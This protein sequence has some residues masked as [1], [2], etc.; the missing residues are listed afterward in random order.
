MELLTEAP[1]LSRV[2]S[3]ASSLMISHVQSHSY[4]CGEDE[5]PVGIAVVAAAPAGR[6]EPLQ[7]SGSGHQADLGV[8]GLL[9][10]SGSGFAL[11]AA[12]HRRGCTQ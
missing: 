8:V 12:D 2:S 7:L 9:A 5:C 10:K 4:Y 11:P 1:N 3:S 6:F